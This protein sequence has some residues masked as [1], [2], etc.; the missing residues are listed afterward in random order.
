MVKIYDECWHCLHPVFLADQ[1]TRSLERLKLERLDVC[2]LHNPEYFLEE[3]HRQAADPETSRQEFYRRIR[4]AF[5]HFEEEVRAGR[6]EWYGVSSNSPGA[7]LGAPEATSL[8]SMLEAAKRAA[9]EAG[10]Q[11]RDQ[12]CALADVPKNLLWP[13]PCT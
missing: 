3:A 6:I 1:L 13:A 7:D 10:R 4:V 12:H 9:P 5:T 8:R 11:Q 2:L